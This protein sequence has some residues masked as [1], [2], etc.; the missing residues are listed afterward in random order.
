MKSSG[1]VLVT[2]GAGF[3]GSHLVDALINRGYRVRVLDS[4]SPPVHDGHLPPWF[5]KKAEFIRGDVRKKSDWIKS[6]KRVEYVFHL[7]AYMDYH[8]DFSKYF[9]TNTRSTALLYEI[10][11]KQNLP[12]K[13]IV[14]A[15]SQSVYGEGKYRCA[16][17]GIFYAQARPQSRLK[18]HEWE[19][20][21]PQDNRVAQTLPEEEFDE[22][23]PQTPY[24]I[25]KAA[26][27]HLSLTLGKIYEVPTV[28]LRY[29]VVH[30]T[31]QS[32]RHFYS[33]ALRDFSIRA[34]SKKPIV[35]QEDGQ[36][37]RD[38][39][40][41]ANV[42]NAHLLVL[43]NKK[44]DY[45]VFN[46]GSGQNTRVVDLAKAVSKIAGVPYKIQLAGEFRINSPR[47]SKMDVSK[48]KKLGWQPKYKLEDN[49]RQ[50]VEWIGNYPKAIYYWD[51]TYTK[52]RRRKI[53]KR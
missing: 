22:L 30:G 6:L 31:R 26:S 9:D 17:H 18:K 15:S 7:A 37:I 28:V 2:G 42:V 47:H 43:K 3:I 45:Q 51:K 4:L 5:N 8:P 23:H 14:I 36:Q 1:I 19:I 25:S 41:V 48:L 49:V 50:Y 44:A 20:V 24:A 53:L 40:N 35:I 39:V 33:G 46:V 11:V 21:C 32:Y 52:M 38:F 29:S 16:K 34:L 13:K 10:A 27:E 12:I